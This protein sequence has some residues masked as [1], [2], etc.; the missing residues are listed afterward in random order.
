MAE[1]D[2]NGSE[3]SLDEVIRDFETVNRDL[4]ELAI[5]AQQLIA[6]VELLT[7]ARD[8]ISDSTAEASARYD[9]AI[10]EANRLV[11][12]STSHTTQSLEGLMER[13]LAANTAQQAAALESVAL[14]QQV[15]NEALDAAQRDHR[16]TASRIQDVLT[17]L[18]D[19]ARHLAD[20]AAAFRQ[21]EPDT[22]LKHVEHI[23]AETGRMK[24]EGRIALGAILATLGALIAIVL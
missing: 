22:M 9:E 13:L 17:S 21:L 23:R 11:E 18:K 5:N 1:N 10:A 8:I 15:A 4:S 6:T 3:K 16:N 19:S 24:T 12:A 14:V 20:T 7:T 2:G